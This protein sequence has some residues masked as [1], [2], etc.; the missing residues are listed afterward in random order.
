VDVRLPPTVSMLL[1]NSS[2]TSGLSRAKMQ[3]GS[4]RYDT[5][6]LSGFARG[7]HGGAGDDERP[8]NEFE[9]GEVL[10]KTHRSA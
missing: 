6:G 1:T 7:S 3:A 2:E 8:T 9:R 4:L 10:L 5:D